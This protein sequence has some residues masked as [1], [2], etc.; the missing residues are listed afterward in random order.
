MKKSVKFITLGN[1]DELLVTFSNL[2]ASIYSIRF[3]HRLMT[4]TPKRKRD[5][6]LPEIYHGK[7]IGPVCG[8]IKNGKLFIKDKEYV[9]P[10]NEG[11]NTLH[12]GPDGFSTQ[13]FD[14]E[15]IDNGIRF[16]FEDEKGTYVVEY[17]I[18]EN[19][20]RI[21]FDVTPKQ[22][23]PLAMTNHSYFTL[24]K[25]NILKTKLQINASKFIEVN[26]ND[27]LPER[28]KTVPTCLDFRKPRNIGRCINNPYLQESVTKGY[29]H[30]FI[31]DDMG[32]E[33]VLENDKYCLTIK[34]DFTAVQ[35]Y[36]DNYENGVEMINTK[37]NIYR[38]IAIEPQDNQLERQ[39]FKDR[40]NKFIEYRFDRK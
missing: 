6:V 40:Y 9:F 2:G 21:D 11:K 32:S 33:I 10:L 14:D 38:G 23:I 8:R 24:G 31:L 37:G 16:T 30:S 34:S 15:L 29:D 39:T 5:F 28:I 13:I 17:Q 3:N 26:P 36:S 20:L 4:L 27:L 25:K 35:V 22:E 7:T 18:K 12:G 19:T 1:K